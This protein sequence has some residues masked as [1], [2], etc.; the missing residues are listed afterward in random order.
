MCGGK[1]CRIVEKSEMG[2]D[3]TKT[4][5]LVMMCLEDGSWTFYNKNTTPFILCICY[6]DIVNVDIINNSSNIFF[7]YI[8]T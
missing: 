1:G 7:Y 8:C 3:V 4:G 2:E 6:D 5:D